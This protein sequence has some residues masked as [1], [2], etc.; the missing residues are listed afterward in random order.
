GVS[1][2]NVLRRGISWGGTLAATWFL[3]G[4]LRKVRD[5][6][7]GYFALRKSVIE[8]VRLTPEGYKILLEV[9]VRGRVHKVR[10][11][12]YTFVKRERGGSKLG[13]RQ[14]MEYVQHLFR[15]SWEAG[16]LKRFMKYCAVGATG[17]VVNTAVLGLCMSAG[18]EP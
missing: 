8:G 14:M 1:K 10:E 11:I 4:T 13:P 6:M 2:W 3:P 12:P 18:R 16:D 9:L 5:P 7:S 15:L 17:V